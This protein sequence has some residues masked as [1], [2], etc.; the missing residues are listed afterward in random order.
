M[1]KVAAFVAIIVAGHLAGRSRTLGPR[2]EQCVSKIVFTFT[3]PCAIVHAFGAAEFTHDLLIL[4]PLGLACAL[5]PYLAVLGHPPLRASRPRVLPAQL[6]RL[7][8]R[9]LLLALRADALPRATRGDH[10]PVRCGQRHHDDRRLLRTHRPRRGQRARRASGEVR[11]EDA[12]IILIV[13]AV[14]EIRIPDA[15][16]QFTAPIANANSFLAMFMLGLM[17]RFEIDRNK[18]AKVARLI[19]LRVVVSAVASALAFSFLPFDATTRIVI[20]MLLWA[21]A[22]AMG[23]TFTLWSDGD[24][25]LAGLAN[26]LTIILG[27]IA[28]T[29]IVLASGVVA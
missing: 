2:P 8:H 23:P 24:F 7:Q 6:L 17:I 9:V 18:L 12:Y 14:A 29:T 16:V 13:L 19:G 3:L 26:A 11:R 22:S 20:V 15:I 5:I 28:T 21:P 1:L 10:L 25:G 4:V 27:V